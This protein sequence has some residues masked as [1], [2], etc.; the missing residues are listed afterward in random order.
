MVDVESISIRLSRDTKT[1]AITAR[2][3]LMID[4][5]GSAMVVLEGKP[6]QMKNRMS[7]VKEAILEAAVKP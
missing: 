3:S 5:P 1:E 4:I 6:D 2:Y 7:K